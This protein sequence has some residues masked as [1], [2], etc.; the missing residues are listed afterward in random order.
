MFTDAYISSLGYLC[1]STNSLRWK[2]VT[3]SH[4]VTVSLESPKLSSNGCAL[5]IWTPCI[6]MHDITT[7]VANT[8]WP[9][10]FA[11]LVYSKRTR[12][13]SISLLFKFPLNWILYSW[14]PFLSHSLKGGRNTFVLKWNATPRYSEK[15]PNLIWNLAALNAFCIRSRCRAMKWEALVVSGSMLASPGLSRKSFIYLFT[16]RI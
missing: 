16:E 15:E 5:S 13:D 7:S 8:H 6:K 3:I 14:I 4:W 12:G 1:F 10:R 2:F 11:A 9:I